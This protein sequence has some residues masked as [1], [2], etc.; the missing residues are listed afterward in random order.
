MDTKKE[1]LIKVKIKRGMGKQIA[2]LFSVTPEF[3]SRCASG[4]SNTELAAKIRKTAV[5]LG[6]DAIFESIN[7]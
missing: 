7:N 6:G 1:K 4:N 3:V 2:E 5:E